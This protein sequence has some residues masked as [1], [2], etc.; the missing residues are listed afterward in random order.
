[1]NTRR[2]A[3]AIAAALLA[4]SFTAIS[5]PAEARDTGW[6]RTTN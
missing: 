3:S 2:S 4:L 5:A 1:M 6:T